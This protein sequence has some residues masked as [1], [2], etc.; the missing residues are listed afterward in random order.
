[1]ADTEQETVEISFRMSQIIEHMLGNTRGRYCVSE[2]S[3]AL[4]LRTGTVTPLMR[5]MAEVG[6]L[7]A[8]TEPRGRHYPKT[9]YRF[10]TGTAPMLRRAIRD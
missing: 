4:G 6:W 8:E 7:T 9:W 1:M 5:R 2:V 3:T 10:T